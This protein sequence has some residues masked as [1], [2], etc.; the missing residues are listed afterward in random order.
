VR[1]HRARDDRARA[2]DGPGTDLDAAHHARVRADRGSFPND[3]RDDLPLTPRAGIPIVRE[4][5]ARTDEH[6]VLER[7][8]VVDGDVVLDL[9]AV[10]DRGSGVDVDVVA[11]R[12]VGADDRAV[13]NMRVMPDTSSLADP[14]T[15]LDDG[16]VV[17]EVRGGVV[18]GRVQYDPSAAAPELGRGNVRAPIVVRSSGS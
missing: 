13:A 1:V 18:Q 14:G 4:D 3:R 16:T 11:E 6:L 7:H 5:G 9:H 15:R 8:S 17:R 12:A 2:D 10:A